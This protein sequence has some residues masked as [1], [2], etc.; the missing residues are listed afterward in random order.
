MILSLYRCGVCVYFSLVCRMGTRCSEVCIHLSLLLCCHLSAL[1]NTI[2][3]VIKCES[4][5][6]L[7]LRI[8]V[9]FWT[10]F[11]INVVYVFFFSFLMFQ[12]VVFYLGSMVALKK[13]LCV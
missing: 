4:Y 6:F 10:C 7:L 9:H 1:V 8:F 5:L 13:D 12:A 2:L 11:N 3:D